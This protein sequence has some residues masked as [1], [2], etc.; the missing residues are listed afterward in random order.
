VDSLPRAPV[1]ESPEAAAPPPPSWKRRAWRI[2]RL[3][4]IAYIG[5]VV[6]LMF[7]ENMMVYQPA[8]ASRDWEAPPSPDIEEVTLVSADGT[9]IHAWWL[10]CPE[11]KSAL[12]YLHGNAGNLSWRGRSILKVREHLGV[13]VLII[14]YPG[15]GKSEGRP[16]EQGCYQ[17]ADAAY[18]WLTAAQNIPGERILVWGVSL[19]GGVAVDLGSRRPCQALI[20]LKTF[21]TLPDVAGTIYPWVPT[22]WL[23]RNS[24]DNLDKIAKCRCPVFI[25]HGTT[26]DLI[27]DAL[28]RKLYD[29][30]HQPKEFFSMAGLGHNDSL[31]PAM[32]EALKTFLAKHTK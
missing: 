18:D 22:R 1:T 27:P 11:A 29:A 26:D 10:P 8:S 20:L 17:A 19:G 4:L 15:Y 12:L 30:A 28:G 14:D 7:F 23:M 5:V 9:N 32:F 6:L 21:T 16:S 24:F 25:T 2:V 13:S 31:T 3:A